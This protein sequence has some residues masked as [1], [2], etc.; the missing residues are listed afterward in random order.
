MTLPVM[1]RLKALMGRVCLEV[2]QEGA[3]LLLPPKGALDGRKNDGWN[4]GIQCSRSMVGKH[5][6]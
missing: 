4:E 3:I 6:R 1:A 2:S 5:N